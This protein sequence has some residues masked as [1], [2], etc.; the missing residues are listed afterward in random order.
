MDINIIFSFMAYNQ[1][2]SPDEVKQWCDN[3]FMEANVNI[4][5]ELLSNEKTAARMYEIGEDSN[6][7]LYC[8]LNEFAD[9]KKVKHLKIIK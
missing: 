6:G 8:K 2:H 7:L 1:V 4:I 9:W 5:A 3:D